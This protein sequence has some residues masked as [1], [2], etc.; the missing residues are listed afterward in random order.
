VIAL[1]QQHITREALITRAIDRRLNFSP[2][3]QLM[4]HGFLGEKKS[5]VDFLRPTSL[6]GGYFISRRDGKNSEH[7]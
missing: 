7:N 5:S 4:F 2:D 1:V 3:V 6:N